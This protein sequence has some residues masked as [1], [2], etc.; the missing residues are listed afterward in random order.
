[1]PEG[2]SSAAP[3]T[4]PGP[5]NRKNM[6]LG[7]LGGP[8]DADS[9]ISHLRTDPG[10]HARLDQRFTPPIGACRV[11]RPRRKKVAAITGNRG[12]PSTTIARLDTARSCPPRAG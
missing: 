7:F 6:F 11:E 5:S 8:E 4:N 9:V 1:M 10:G 3:V 12:W 2:S